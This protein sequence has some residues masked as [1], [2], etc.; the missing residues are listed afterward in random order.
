MTVQMFYYQGMD[1]K[2]KTMIVMSENGLT[3]KQELAVELMLA[4]MSDGDI[5]ERARV[6]RKTINTWRNQNEDFRAVLAKRRKA[7]RER[8]QDELSGLVSEAIGVMREAM[9]EGIL[10]PACERRRRCCAHRDSRH[11]CKRKSQLHGKRSSVNSSA[12]RLGRWH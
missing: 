2:N 6:S 11:R 1:K 8:H 3:D 7:T 5:A 12:K 10:S 4:G 9:Q